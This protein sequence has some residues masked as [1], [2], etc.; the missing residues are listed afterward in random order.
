MYGVKFKENR[1]LVGSRRKSSVR[2]LGPKGFDL[3]YVENDS[4]NDENCQANPSPFLHFRFNRFTF[5]L[6]EERFARTAERVDTAGIAR[7]Q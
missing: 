1:R 7:L 3:Q 2:E 5:I 6:T 4:Q